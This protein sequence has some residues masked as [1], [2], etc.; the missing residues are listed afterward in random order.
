[1]VKFKVTGRWP[2]RRQGQE[3]GG[4]VKEVSEDHRAGG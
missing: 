3:E 4:A 1:M 2:W